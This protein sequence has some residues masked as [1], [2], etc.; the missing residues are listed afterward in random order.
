VVGIGINGVGQTTLE[1]AACIERAERLFYLVLDPLAE[2]WIRQ[3]NP[4]AVSLADLYGEGKDRKQTYVEMTARIVEA[5]RSGFHVCAVFYGHPGVLVKSSHAAI[6]QLRREGY[7]ARMLP[8]VSADGCLYADLGFNPGDQGV[9][10]FEATDFLRARRRIDPTSGLILWQVG[11]LGEVDARRGITCRPERL[12]TL[13]TFLSR[14]YSP[15]HRVVLYY[16]P[17]FPADP[18]IVT[19]VTLARLA[20]TKVYPLAMLFVPPLEQ[21]RPDPAIVRWAAEAR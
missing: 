8:G 6:A 18:P 9:Q 14:H 2:R 10:S 20:R 13:V 5:V 19:R 15:N 11:V 17:T 16:A 7:R 4:R 21:R 3:L 1:A 12:A